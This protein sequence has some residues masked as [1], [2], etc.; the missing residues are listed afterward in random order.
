MRSNSIVKSCDMHWILQL[1]VASRWCRGFVAAAGI[2]RQLC[3]ALRGYRNGHKLFRDFALVPAEEVA[4]VIVDVVAHYIAEFGL[5]EQTGKVAD[6]NLQTDGGLLAI[7]DGAFL[8]FVVSPAF[9]SYSRGGSLSRGRRRHRGGSWGIG[10]GV[11][12]R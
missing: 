7:A 8:V 6:H 9:R 2:A 3:R 5:F 12:G 4:S 1:N 11:V 10:F